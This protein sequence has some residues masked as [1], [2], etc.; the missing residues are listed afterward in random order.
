MPYAEAAKKEEKE[1]TTSVSNSGVDANLK[2]QNLFFFLLFHSLQ[3]PFTNRFSFD[4]HS[5][6]VSEAN[7]KERGAPVS[8]LQGRQAGRWRAADLQG[9][10]L[11]KG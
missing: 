9:Y 2:I 3:S 8:V 5:S 4:S 7:Q 11:S 6:H 1:R 10:V